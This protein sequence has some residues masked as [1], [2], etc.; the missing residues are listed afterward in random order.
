MR[1]T[2]YPDALA[3]LDA[4]VERATDQT[5]DLIVRSGLDEDEADAAMQRFYRELDRVR[6]E[7]RLEIDEFF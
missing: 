5:H 7:C 2:S 4:A 3:R 1:A 6:E